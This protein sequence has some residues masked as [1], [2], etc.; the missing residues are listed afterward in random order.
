MTKKACWYVPETPGGTVLMH[1]KSR[2]EK[3]AWRNLMKDAA[4]MPYRTQQDFYN[5]GY[6]VNEIPFDKAA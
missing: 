1:L 5:R 3:T 6:R 4:H 2:T